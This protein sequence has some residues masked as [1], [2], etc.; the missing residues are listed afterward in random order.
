MFPQ[1]GVLRSRRKAFGCSRLP[2]KWGI[3][4]GHGK[5]LLPMHLRISPGSV[6]LDLNVAKWVRINLSTGSVALNPVFVRQIRCTGLPIRHDF[7][8]SIVNLQSSLPSSLWW[9]QNSS[10]DRIEQQHHNGLA[11]RPFVLRTA[12]YITASSAVYVSS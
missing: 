8:S 1:D 4:G 3:W 7:K 11:P 10:R 6:N 5:L 2:G 12:I 9:L